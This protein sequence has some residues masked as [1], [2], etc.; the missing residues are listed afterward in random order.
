MSDLDLEAM[1][2]NALAGFDGIQPPMDNYTTTVPAT[3][4]AARFPTASPEL[5]RF[6]NRMMKASSRSTYMI[7]AMSLPLLGNVA[8][9][10]LLRLSQQNRIETE[11]LLADTGS[12]FERDYRQLINI[13]MPSR[14]VFSDAPLFFANEL[15]ITD[16][17]DRETVRMSNLASTAASTFGANDVSLKD[18][19]DHFLAIFVPEDGEYKGSLSSFFVDLKTQVFI[20]SLREHEDSQHAIGLIDDLFPTEFE[21]SLTE[22][23]GEEMLNPDEAVLVSQIKERRGLLLNSIN[24][25]NIKSGFSLNPPQRHTAN[26]HCKAS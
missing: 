25:E 16:S 23:S 12:E 13:F 3:A 26:G 19:H 22:R 21:K 15:K 6:E 7:R 18:I 11:L 20:D 4:P 2:Q 9:Q 10:I 8:V 5:D 14:K 1:M 17:D 24:D